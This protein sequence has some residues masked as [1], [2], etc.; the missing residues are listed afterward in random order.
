M[1]VDRRGKSKYVSCA[2]NDTLHI[3]CYLIFKIECRSNK[4]ASLKFQFAKLLN[5]LSF[6][7]YGKNIWDRAETEVKQKMGFI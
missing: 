2:L 4:L 6:K 1:K 3:A 5:T 7:Q